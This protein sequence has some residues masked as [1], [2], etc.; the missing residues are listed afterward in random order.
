MLGHS[1][2]EFF[3]V[4]QLALVS[5]KFS[6]KITGQKEISDP[7]EIK[8]ARKDGKV[9]WLEIKSWLIQNEK[10]GRNIVGAARVI[11]EQKIAIK[12][13]E[14]SE[15]RLE[16]IIESANDG[17]LTVNLRH[18][19]VYVNS[20]TLQMFG[21]ERDEVIGKRVT[22]FIPKDEHLV[23]FG[24]L[25]SALSQRDNQRA[26]YRL[27][28]LKK[29]GS[30]FPFEF[31]V[32]IIPEGKDESI[33]IVLRDITAQIEAEEEKNR[34]ILE[35]ARKQEEIERIANKLT[36]TNAELLESRNELAEI[37]DGKDKFFSII[38]HDLKGPFSGLISM[39]EYLRDEAHS[40]SKE[41]IQ[42]LSDTILTSAKLVYNL[43]NNLLQWSRVQMG[44]VTPHHDRVIVD[45][46][47][48]EIE[49]LYSHS[50]TEKSIELILVSFSN[51]YII[52]D[53][54][55]ILTVLRNLVSNAI[56]FTPQ[57]GK[58][59]LGARL[60]NDSVEISIQDT[61][62]GMPPQLIKNLFRIDRK[63]T[64]VGTAHEEGTG[65][66]LIMAKEFIKKNGGSISLHSQEGEGSTFTV[67]LPLPKKKSMAD[68]KKD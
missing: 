48:H 30:T 24:H 38:A 10:G 7:Y 28:G 1:F 22:D 19:L 52:A 43:L 59:L 64:R 21:Y 44:R 36:I 17:I 2:A 11:T 16:T 8:F 23:Y 68:K 62:I 58:V 56:K 12:K 45:E 5:S 6:E 18:Y 55:M 54:H 65:M 46:L 13:L 42:E 27:H 39:S 53:R 41:E 61:G 33:T 3:D 51:A 40:S 34:Y 50:A 57:G 67:A 32:S 14:W 26:V 66:G 35:L 9:E 63:V 37:N 20:S 29:D 15:R 31:T 25:K 60:K 4:D 47:L 49:R